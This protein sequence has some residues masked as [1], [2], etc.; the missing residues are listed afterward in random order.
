MST[1]WVPEVREKAAGG[2]PWGLSAEGLLPEALSESEVVA[3]V[4]W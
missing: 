4:L 1:V 2:L 3:G